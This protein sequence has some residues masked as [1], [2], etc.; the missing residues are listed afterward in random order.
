MLTSLHHLCLEQER[1][2]FTSAQIIAV[3]TSSHFYLCQVFVFVILEPH[4]VLFPGTLY[5]CITAGS[6]TGSF[7][8]GQF[9]EE[10]VKR[11]MAQL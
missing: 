4:F 5:G 11:S 1:L 3:K 7:Q 8:L 10:E 2:K 6:D 9:F